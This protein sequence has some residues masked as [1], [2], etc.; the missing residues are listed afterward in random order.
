[1]PFLCNLTVVQI[2]LIQSRRGPAT[3]FYPN[4]N[5]QSPIQQSASIQ[6]HMVKGDATGLDSKETL[7]KFINCDSHPRSRTDPKFHSSPS[8]TFRLTIGLVRY[9]PASGSVSIARPVIAKSRQPFGGSCPWCIFAIPSVQGWIHWLCPCTRSILTI[10]F[11]DKAPRA[12]HPIS[13]IG[14]PPSS[15]YEFREQLIV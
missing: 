5:Q 8:N 14:V 2:A 6:P 15:G 13:S 10:F 7:R 9:R 11:G 3:F 12:T 4:I 1:M